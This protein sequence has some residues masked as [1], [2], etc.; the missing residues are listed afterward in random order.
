[1]DFQWRI[2]SVKSMTYT[3]YVYQHREAD[4]R[5]IFYVGKGKNRRAWK[6]EKRN[7]HWRAVV[8]QHGFIPE[9]LFRT[10]DHDFAF[11]IEEEAINLYKSRGMNLTNM[12]DGGAGGRGY[13][14]TPEHIARLKSES[15]PRSPMPSF[16][17]RKHS[18]ESKKIMSELRLGKDNGKWKGKAR[19]I[20]SRM[21]MSAAKKGRPNLFLRKLTDQQV[22]E[23]RET[24]GYRQVAE[25]ARRYGVGESTIRRIRDG[26]YYVGVV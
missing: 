22:S 4:T 19:S 3:H 17:G 18:D 24:I 11:F 15:W 7:A 14:H 16:A 10:D 20:E 25:F 6:S 8:D 26:I 12:R 5:R 9:I 2:S 23:I 1:M 13:R 21:K